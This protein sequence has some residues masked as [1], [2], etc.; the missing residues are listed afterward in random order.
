LLKGRH[1]YPKSVV[2]LLEDDAPPILFARGNLDILNKESVGF[3]GSRKATDKG[4]QVAHLSSHALAAEGL[5]IVSGYAH[6]VDLTTHSAALEACGVTSIVLAEGILNFKEKNKI[7]DLLDEKNQVIISECPPTL[8]W[9]AGNAMR[10]NRL[11]CG[12]SKALIVIESGM[13]GGTFAAGNKALELGIPLFV[14]EYADDLQAYEGNKYFLKKGAI[15]LRGNRTGIPNISKIR[16]AIKSRAIS[17]TATHQQD[18][19][20]KQ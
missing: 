4:L 15:A 2:S 8:P 19:L 11:I 13:D 10:R 16:E 5:N 6:G 7:K 1:P 14:A 3:C 12:L 9:N 18:D 17:N 20:F